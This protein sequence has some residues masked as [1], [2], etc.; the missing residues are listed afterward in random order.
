MYREVLKVL[1]DCS[2]ETRDAILGGWGGDRDRWGFVDVAKMADAITRREDALEVVR[3][4]KAV[5][6]RGRLRVIRR[7]LEGVNR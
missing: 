7:A 1:G 6:E 2:D 4:P 3:G 5:E